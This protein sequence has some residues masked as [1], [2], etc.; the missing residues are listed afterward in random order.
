MSKFKVGDKVRVISKTR[1][2]FSL[3]EFIEGNG[4]DISV[5]TKVF[6]NGCCWVN[7]Y[8]FN[9]SD[10]ELL[11]TN[12]KNIMSTITK[13][14][15]DL[16]LSADEK[17]LR[18]YNLKTDCGDYTSESINVLLQDICK[19]RE[20]RLIEIANGLEAENKS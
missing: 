13:F 11:T 18:K 5:V 3:G 10:L 15:K 14:V 20:A 8:D 12:K 6:N 19:E 9:E 17:L 2:S 7:G 16:G 4:S 1:G